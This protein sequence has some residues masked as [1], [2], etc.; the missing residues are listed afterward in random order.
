M[1]I[2]IFWLKIETEIVQTLKIPVIV[3]VIFVQFSAIE[4]I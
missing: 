4:S 1:K 3:I 2:C